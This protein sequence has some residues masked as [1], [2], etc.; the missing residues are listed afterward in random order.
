MSATSAAHRHRR[1][2]V[3][4]CGVA[5]AQFIV[6][7]W[8]LSDAFTLRKQFSPQALARR[9]QWFG[10]VN[11]C[12]MPFILPFIIVYFMF[13]YAE[14]FQSKKDYL[15]P[16][17]WSPLAMW[18][19]REFNELPHVLERRCA[20]GVPCTRCESAHITAVTLLSQTQDELQL[21]AR[22]AVSKAVPGARCV[23][24]RQVRRRCRSCKFWL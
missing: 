9:F 22:D 19:F 8:M 20:T 17:M 12:L 16:R 3:C 24:D 5:C 7:D 4:S 21:R 23:Y 14:E 2:D 13:K 10:V 15:G 18:K 11:L 1:A 6:L